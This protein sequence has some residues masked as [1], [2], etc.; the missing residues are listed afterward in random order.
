MLV[1]VLI[2]EN[3]FKKCNP[4]CLGLS[5]A[6][7]WQRSGSALV[8]VMACCLTAPCPYLK[9]HWLMVLW[10]SPKMDF[11]GVPKTSVRVWEIYFWNYHLSLRD[12]WVNT[13]RPK[14]NC[15]HFAGDIFKCIFLNESVWISVKISLKFVPKG[16]INSIPASAQI[17]AWGRP[18]DKPLSELMMFRLL[19]HICVT[20]LHWVNS[21]CPATM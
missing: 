17:M 7:W 18:G 20:W 16:P 9:Q 21:C 19:T 13:L 8:Q 1:K 11:T 12:Q 2:K 10:Q 15:R 5:Y 4:F 14:Q 3:E 6:I